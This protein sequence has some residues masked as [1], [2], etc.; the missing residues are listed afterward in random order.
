[1]TGAG[2]ALAAAMTRLRPAC[3]AA[4]IA[5]SARF[6]QLS[7]LS[8]GSRALTPMLTVAGTAGCTGA[9]LW[10]YSDYA[11]PIWRDPPLDEAVHERHFGL[12]RADGSPK[13]VVAELARW[14]GAP[15]GTAPDDGWID[16]TELGP[17][18]FYGDPRSHLVRL[19]AAYRGSVREARGDAG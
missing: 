10:C 1:M 7:T 8:R 19:Y 14:R 6:T 15:R 2:A 4:Y 18:D 11:R 12:W 16:P 5:S 9:L 13:P 3:L 17:E